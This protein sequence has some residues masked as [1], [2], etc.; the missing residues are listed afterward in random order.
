MRKQD[1]NEKREEAREYSI[2]EISKMFNL[3]I[4]TL[5]YYEEEGILDKVGRTEGKQR[6]YYEMH[7]NRLRTICCFKR[8]GMTI[9]ELKKFFQYEETEEESIDDIVELLE[10]RKRAVEK[11]LE[12]L[13]KDYVHVQKKLNFYSDIRKALKEGKEKPCWEDYK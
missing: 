11:Q 12:E 6:I 5:R 3:P 2:R 4:S 8:A 10:A 13:Q 9:G 7:V 1:G